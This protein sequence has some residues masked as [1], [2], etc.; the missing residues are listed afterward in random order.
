MWSQ[1]DSFTITMKKS[2][3]L[4]CILNNEHKMTLSIN[5]VINN[6]LTFNDEMRHFCMFFSNGWIF[7]FLMMI[8]ATTKKKYA[9]KMI[10]EH[11]INQKNTQK[12]LKQ[13]LLDSNGMEKN[14]NALISRV[15]IKTRFRNAIEE[16]CP[17]GKKLYLS[18]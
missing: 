17:K 18:R 5:I 7:G 8:V 2:L 3:F 15:Y 4:P 14:R 1:I 11:I 6:N 16:R 12:D 10:S 13:W 9:N